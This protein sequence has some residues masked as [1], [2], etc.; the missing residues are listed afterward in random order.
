M[1]VVIDIDENCLE[2][3]VIIKCQSLNDE[4]ALLQKNIN[5]FSEYVN[6]D[7]LNII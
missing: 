6:Q 3:K 5:E 2:S 1:K 4:V 7:I